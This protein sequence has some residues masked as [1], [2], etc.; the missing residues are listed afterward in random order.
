MCKK[1]CFEGFNLNFSE[2]PFIRMTSGESV[3]KFVHC[4]R[5]DS[6]PV[7]KTTSTPH[8][9]PTLPVSNLFNNSCTERSPFV[10]KRLLVRPFFNVS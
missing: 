1:S 8:V 10:Y 4:R 3:T 7:G 6:F 9:D 2:S 5:L